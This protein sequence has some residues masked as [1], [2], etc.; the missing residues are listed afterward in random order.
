MKL[1]DLNQIEESIN[2]SDFDFLDTE[3]MVELNS[4]NIV[5]ASEYM[6][7]F[8][9]KK[10]ETLSFNQKITE[11]VVEE[12]YK[13]ND[14]DDPDC[15][16]RKIFIDKFNTKCIRIEVTPSVCRICG[17]DVAA[18]RHGRW[19][20]VPAS[21][22]KTVVEALDQHKRVVHTLGDLHIVKKSQLPKQWFGSNNL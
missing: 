18:A 4:P 12:A 22:R 13:Q 19:G 21:E 11:E 10:Q 20:L 14:P 15:V 2:S 5:P 16:V 7:T 1:T 17:F 8:N 9:Q 3:P 6:E